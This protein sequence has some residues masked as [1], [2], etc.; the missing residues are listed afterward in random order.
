MYI[1][2]VVDDDLFSLYR[3]VEQ[4]PAGLTSLPRDKKILAEKIAQSIASEHGLARRE[5]QRILLVL[6]DPVEQCIAGV[7]GLEREK[8]TAP[9]YVID[10]EQACLRLETS[11]ISTVKLGSLLL[12]DAYRGHGHGGLL[13]KSR[14][15]YMANFQEQLSEHVH[16][17]LRGW[18]DTQDVSPFW[19]TLGHPLYGDN[20]AAIDH[21]RGSQP[22]LFALHHLAAHEV[23]FHFLDPE[24]RAHIGQVHPDTENALR[25]LVQ[26]NFTRTCYMDIL[27]GGPILRATTSEILTIRN[28]EVYSVTEAPVDDSLLEIWMISNG[29]IRGFRACLHSAQLRAGILHVHPQTLSALEIQPGDRVRATL[30]KASNTRNR[31]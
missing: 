10:V 1:R 22:E 26:E 30:K 4:A 29:R 17:E 27:D 28:S 12:R 25:L 16:A 11:P 9:H 7:S 31:P 24:V 6:Y 2:S 23:P 20:F 3:L 8:S 19:R 5:W 14:F 18:V 15:L 21:F 13:S